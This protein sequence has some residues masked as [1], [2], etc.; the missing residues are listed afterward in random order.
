MV[1]PADL[2]HVR[3]VKPV[4]FPASDP[5]WEMGQSKR[6]LYLCDLLLLVLRGALGDK[7]AVGCDQFVYFDASDPRRKCAPDAFVKLGVPDTL[8]DSWKTWERDRGTPDVCVEILSPSDTTETLTWDEKMERYLALGVAEVVAF[9]ADAVA[10][11]RLR[12]WDRLADDLVE[13]EIRAETTP[14]APLGLHWV[15]VPS[16]APDGSE[17]PAA[18]RLAR[19]PLGADLVPT[20]AEA[21]KTAAQAERADAERRADAADARAKAADA[22]NARLRAELAA[23]R[24]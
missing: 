16:R 11:S 24:R 19:D 3:P 18:L 9:N 22:E 2:P 4:L 8:F 1:S 23:A 10:G 5:E 14:C 21:E 17:L 6:H 20:R 13:R 7:H 15:V 12:A